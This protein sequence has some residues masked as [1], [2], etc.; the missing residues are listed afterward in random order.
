MKFKYFGIISLGLLAF[1]ACTDDS[2][3]NR[4][5]SAPGVTVDMKLADYSARES[6]TYFYVPIQ[7]NGTTNGPVIV[8]VESKPTSASPAVVDENYNITSDR[9]IIPAG[10]TEGVVEVQPIDDAV[11]NDSRYFDLSIVRVEG[12]SLGSSLTT[13][14]ELRDNDQDPYEKMTGQWVMNGISVFEDG[15][16]GP[17]VLT[18]TTPDPDD[19]D[20]APYYGHELYGYGLYGMNNIFLPFNFVY[21]EATDE[22]VMSIQTDS[23]CSYTAFN[24]GSFHGVLVGDSEYNPTSLTCGPEIPLTVVREGGKVVKLVASPDDMFLLKI[25]KYPDMDQS[26]GYLE[27]WSDIELVRQ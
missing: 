2:D 7:V 10:K 14:V 1:S 3:Y 9:I 8:Y 23:F 5:N 19:E 12:A 6:G 4:V 11:E 21:K 24:F 17:F 27:G 16:N 20:E 18:L 25:Y 26:M 15:E 13:V 22:I